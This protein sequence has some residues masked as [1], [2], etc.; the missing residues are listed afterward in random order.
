MAEA[1]RRLIFITGASSGI[2]QALATRYLQAGWRVALVARRVA[3]MRE[4]ASSQGWPVS[5]WAVYEADVRD[6]A[7]IAAAAQAC[8]ES[9]GLPDVVVAN[10]GISIGVDLS[11]AEDLTVLRDL[12][13]TNVIGLAATFQPFISAMKLRGHGTLVGVASVAAIRGMPGH[14]GYCAAKAAVVQM[15]ETLR[16]ELR[17]HG[18]RVVTLAPGYI[19]T[20]LT[21]ANQYPMPFLMKAEAFADQAFT[22]IGQGVR[23]RVIP[24]PMGLVTMLLRWMPRWLFDAIAGSQ[25]HRK[26]QRRQ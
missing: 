10:A 9:Q 1:S 21:R 2:G 14:A 8:M 18:V 19:D 4:W 24:W 26:K 22:A 7:A 5:Q 23:W 15:C 12:M 25:Q 20:P 13:D 3:E 17:A 11:L 6:E 16:G